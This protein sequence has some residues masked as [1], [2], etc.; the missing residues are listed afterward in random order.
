MRRRCKSA[1]LALTLSLLA[2]GGSSTAP[3]VEAVREDGDAG[4]GAPAATEPRETADAAPPPVAPE[5]GSAGCT[6]AA[7]GGALDGASVDV[8]GT[9]RTFSVEVPADYDPYRKYPLVF[10]LHSGGGT[11]ART[12]SYFDFSSFA[13]SDA[14]FLYPD[15]RRGSWDLDSETAENG[16]VALFDALVAKLSRERCIDPKRIFV[17]GTSNG[18]YFANQLGCRRG[19]VIRAIAPHA[20]G[21]PYSLQGA[22]FDEKGALKCP[23][24]PVAARIFIGLADTQVLP[25][26]GEKSVAHWTRTNGCQA[27]TEGDAPAP[28]VTHAGCERP[29]SVCRL[30]GVGH[31]MWAEGPKATW[32]FFQTFE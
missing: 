3:A 5:G 17:T 25:S 15:G 28:C 4:A 19:D 14:I 23:T 10:V 20:G 13:G 11:G 31:R 9:A 24:A 7:A 8:A 22:M 12:R 6:I 21:G 30:P 29:V 2:C 27:A 26:E 18:A 32:S 1:P 16:D